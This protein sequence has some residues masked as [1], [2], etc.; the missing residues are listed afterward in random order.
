MLDIHW[1]LIYFYGYGLTINIRLC[2]VAESKMLP[3]AYCQRSLPI[4]SFSLSHLL[5][6]FSLFSLSLSLSCSPL[7]RVCV[8]SQRTEFVLGRPWMEN[9]WWWWSHSTR[10]IRIAAEVSERLSVVC[11]L[12]MTMVWVGGHTVLSRVNLDNKYG[13]KHSA[14]VRL[15]GPPETT[16]WHWMILR[17]LL[18][19]PRILLIE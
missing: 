16:R 14:S 18:W 2:G 10:C 3:F 7:R 8:Y 5:Y 19:W 12:I 4:C 11:V 13:L 6:W 1:F 9:W 15:V 17:Q